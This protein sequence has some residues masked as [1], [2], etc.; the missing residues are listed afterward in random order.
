MSP[1]KVYGLLLALVCG[2]TNP[3]FRRGVLIGKILDPSG[4]PVPNATVALQDSDGKVLAWTR[5]DANGEYRLAANPKVALNLKPSHSR[6]LLEECARAAG[7]AVVDAARF[8]GSTV[9]TPGATARSGAVAVASGAPGQDVAAGAASSLPTVGSTPG[10]LGQ[11]AGG[12]AT[13][14]A[15]TGVPKA[16]T[17]AP[18]T[19]GQAALLIVAPGF[20]DASVADAA[21]WM[22]PP[23]GDRKNPVGVQAWMQAVK[24]APN[25]GDKKCELVPAIVSLGDLDV[26]PTLIPAGSDVQIKVKL[27]SPDPN[28]AQKVRIFARLS[29]KNTVVELTP[30]VGQKDFYAGKMA[31]DRGTKAGPSTIS[32]GAL[33]TEPV[34]IRLVGK[35]ADPLLTFASRT[36]DMNGAKP[37]GYDPFVMASQNRLDAKVTILS[38][39]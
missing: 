12:A 34:E 35:K 6:G 27:N 23:G 11:S 37:Y 39:K 5:T 20:K 28:T 15:L 29:P 13:N 24:L 2:T 30:L 26:Q 9:I 10:Q 19:H 31:I 22:D 21:Y 36:D 14:S 7:D 8:V 1:V 32:V 25:P 18:T 38:A 16:Q 33:R 3:D 17:P 4:K